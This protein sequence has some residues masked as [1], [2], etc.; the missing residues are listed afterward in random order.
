MD[1]CYEFTLHRFFQLSEIFERFS[2]SSTVKERRVQLKLYSKAFKGKRL[3]DWL[4]EHHFAKS[5]P[6]GLAIGQRL[7]DC[8]LIRSV[9]GFGEF[10]DSMQ[11]VYTI[12]PR[13]QLAGSPTAKSHFKKGTVLS[14]PTS[15][16]LCVFTSQRTVVFFS[17]RRR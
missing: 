15:L 2:K 10:E 12:L 1:V 14:T 13:P 3:V 16:S 5:R 7:F 4:I 9:L 11:D 17:V 8:N 6:M